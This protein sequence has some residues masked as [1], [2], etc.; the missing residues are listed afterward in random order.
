LPV[1]DLL[2]TNDGNY[3][4][5]GGT[6]GVLV[7]WQ[8][9]T[10]HKSFVPRL[11]GAILHLQQS[12]DD[13][14]IS[15]TLENN[16][17]KIISAVT[18]KLAKTI[19]YLTPAYELPAG[20]SYHL[21]SNCVVLNGRPDGVLQFYDPS[22][23][24][25]RQ[26]IDIIGENLVSS[27]RERYVYPTR[28]KHVA[29]SDNGN[30]MATVD[31]REDRILPT[32]R[33]LKFW[34]Y[35]DLSKNFIL[36]TLVDPPHKG[37]IYSLLI[38]P[39]PESLQDYMAVTTSEDGD[40]KTWVLTKETAAWQLHSIGS[41]GEKNCKGACF[42]QDGSILAVLFSTVTL[43]DPQNLTFQKCLQYNTMDDN[44]KYIS[45]ANN[46]SSQ[47][48]IGY[49]ES[50]LIVWNIN[51]MKDSSIAWMLQ[52]NVQLITCDPFSR[53]FAAF[54]NPI[55]QPKST[56]L[57]L[58]DPVSPSP[59]TIFSHV[60]KHYSSISSAM[61]APQK[62][63]ISGKSIWSQIGQL[64][65]LTENT[66]IFAVK[67]L[68]E[69]DGEVEDKG[70]ENDE[71]SAFE[72]I[73]GSLEH[74]KVGENVDSGQT[75]PVG[76]QQ[77]LVI[78]KMMST[79]ANVLPSSDIMCKAYIKALLFSN[80]L[81]VDVMTMETE[82]SLG[83]DNNQDENQDENN[84]NVPDEETLDCMEDYKPSKALLRKL[85]NLSLDFFTNTF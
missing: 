77:S 62:L 61:F 59:A 15:V 12:S 2:F 72:D 74:V 78:S 64:Y 69:A 36:N 65:I 22:E 39:D 38:R 26:S 52:A 71:T 34:R 20:L 41:Y 42:S 17:I 32:E 53:Y 76:T 23:D 25:V 47:F 54:I 85:E 19:G 24:I 8:I 46:E 51:N 43:W 55:N 11:G 14:Y 7:I 44:V 16:A 28:V 37:S 33:R 63:K 27:V 13:Q 18:Q 57:Y 30:W 1:A 5:S 60:S 70:K 68:V 73:F 29:F 3:V 40:I 50:Y 45:F 75:V 49:S 58:F 67:E 79:P 48:L 6:E 31:E 84:T 56:H 81:P 4:M 9:E 80:L 83:I 35:C 21:P 66:E 82:E 10:Q